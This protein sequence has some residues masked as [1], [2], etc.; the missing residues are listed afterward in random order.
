MPSVER[1]ITTHQPIEKVWAYL[2]DFTT[3][4]EWDP[5]TVT[6]TRTAGD[7]GVGTTYTNVSTFLGHESEVHYVVTECVPL[8][9]LQLKGDAGDSLGLLDTITFARDAAGTAVTYHAQF[10]LHGAAKLAEPLMPLGLKVLADK[11]AKSMQEHLDG[12]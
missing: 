10:E 12:L 6:T 3:T 11:V 8:E 1:T 4:E 9:R 2:S 7:G 5:P